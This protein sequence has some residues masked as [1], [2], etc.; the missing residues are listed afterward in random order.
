MDR[1]QLLAYAYMYDCEVV[2]HIFPEK[3]DKGSELLNELG[4]YEINSK[5]ENQVKYKMLSLRTTT[6]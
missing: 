1:L 3:K 4:E 6:E 5:S 2:G